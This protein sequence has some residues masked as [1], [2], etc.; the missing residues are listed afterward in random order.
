YAHAAASRALGYKGL[1]DY[2]ASYAADGMIYTEK[3]RQASMLA[4]NDTSFII[5]VILLSTL[6]LVLL[7]KGTS[8]SK[9][10]PGVH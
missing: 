4:F 3:L 5:F 1:D 6:P 2:M 10:P 8:G 7:I 9:T